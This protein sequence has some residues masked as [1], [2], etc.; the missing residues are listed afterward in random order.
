MSLCFKHFLRIVRGEVKSKSWRG[1]DLKYQ[2]EDLL[3]LIK[4]LRSSKIYTLCTAQCTVQSFN[5]VLSI[6]KYTVCI[7]MKDL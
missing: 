7:V 4:M 1:V 3:K 5:C 6:V 2:T